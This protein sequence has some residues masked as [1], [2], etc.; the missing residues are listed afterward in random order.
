MTELGDPGP[1]SLVLV[2][3]FSLKQPVLVPEKSYLLKERGG[4]EGLLFG[5]SAP[6]YRGVG[7]SNAPAPRPILR[8]A[9]RSSARHDGSVAQNWGVRNVGFKRRPLRTTTSLNLGSDARK[10][11]VGSC[12]AAVGAELAPNVWI[13]GDTAGAAP[14]RISRRGNGR[15]QK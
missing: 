5:D 12:L 14:S 8:T 3:K 7:L 9:S 4:R 10:S 11:T 6:E 13:G 1:K 2:P 15:T